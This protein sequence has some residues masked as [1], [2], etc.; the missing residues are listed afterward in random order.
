LAE[1]PRPRRSVLFVPG[2]NARAL[3]KARG[4]A[5]DVL[6]FD[7]EDAVAPA[8][9]PAARAAITAALA[10]AGYGARELLLRVNS[11][12]TAWG[13][14]DLAVAARLPL[15]GVLL[16]K[17][18]SA[19][20]VRAAER[21]LVAAGAAPALRLWCM[22]ETPAGILHA[23]EIAGASP[24]VGALMIG[25]ADL[26]KE[27]HAEPGP[28]RLPLL[29]A[30]QTCVLAARA[31]G[32]AA[33]DGIH[34]DLDDDAGFAHAC[35][36]GRAFGFDGKSL[37]HP[38]TIAVANAVFAPAAADIAWAERVVAAH[39]AAVAAGQGVTLL[40]GK[41]IEVLHVEAARRLLALAA[42]IAARAPT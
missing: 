30:L 40:D 34:A 15:D 7:L 4:L 10:Q 33:I 28:D 18:E 29:L 38:K 11:L 20:A 14:D 8:A 42:A 35:R 13:E 31:H 21:C 12:E 26:A 17:I 6:A 39:A 23:A 37:I 32:L 1:S 5:A 19:D 36:Q 25:T 9:K 16:P 22:L 41:L 27:L 2:S 24:R 3:D